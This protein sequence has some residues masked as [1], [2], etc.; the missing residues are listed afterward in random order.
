MN[1]IVLSSL[2]MAG[3]LESKGLIAIACFFREIRG[4]SSE[5]SVLEWG[6]H[7]L[8]PSNLKIVEIVPRIIVKYCY[9]FNSQQT[10]LPVMP[11]IHGTSARVATRKLILR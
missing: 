7:K 6:R 4:E 11:N 8:I 3:P 1:A 10:L 9:S 2:F 5:A